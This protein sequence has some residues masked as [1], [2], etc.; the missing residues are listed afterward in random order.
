MVQSHH[1]HHTL[2]MTAAPIPSTPRNSS[3][4]VPEDPIMDRS[5]GKPGPRTVDAPKSFQMQQHGIW[6]TSV[7]SKWYLYSNN[8]KHWSGSIEFIKTSF[9]KCNL[10]SV[11]ALHILKRCECHT[12]FCHLPLCRV[13]PDA[14]QSSCPVGQA[15]TSGE[16]PMFV[17][18]CNWS[19]VCVTCPCRPPKENEKRINPA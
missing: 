3:L 18:L 5:P 16:Q 7:T 4:R 13:G 11:A 6:V 1:T 10:T 12:S 8:S 17:S 2:R 14:G 9:T 15:R 19:F